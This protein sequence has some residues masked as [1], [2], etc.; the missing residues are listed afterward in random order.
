MKEDERTHMKNLM[1]FFC[2]HYIF[3]LVWRIFSDNVIDETMIPALPRNFLLPRS[4][5]LPIC[6]TP[7]W[8]RS[9]LFSVGILSI[10]LQLFFSNIIWYLV[11][12]Q[13]FQAPIHHLDSFFSFLVDLKMLLISG[14]FHGHLQGPRANQA[15]WEREAQQ[16]QSSFQEEAW[17]R[18]MAT[19]TNR[20]SSTTPAKTKKQQKRQH[21]IP[22]LRQIL[23]KTQRNNEK[24]SHK[25]NHHL[26]RHRFC[27]SNMKYHLTVTVH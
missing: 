9:V 6:A 25:A 12:Q 13:Q 23:A 24:K 8:F 26:S 19:F 21:K 17:R 27:H 2:L 5:R 20:F 4:W 16:K 15:I 10:K 7:A 18:S 14:F 11:T 3:T 22:D 1:T